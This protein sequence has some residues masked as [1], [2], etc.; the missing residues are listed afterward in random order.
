[1][2]KTRG[3]A[4]MRPRIKYPLPAIIELQSTMFDSKNRERGD[5]YLVTPKKGN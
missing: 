1:M 3:S 4:C 5:F 2:R